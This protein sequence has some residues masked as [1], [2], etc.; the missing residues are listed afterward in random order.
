MTGGRFDLGPIANP[1]YQQVA[2]RP[3]FDHQAC[4]AIVALAERGPWHPA[5]LATAGTGTASGTST[6]G[7]DARIRSAELFHLPDDDSW[8]LHRLVEA[9]AEINAE[10][11]RFELTGLFASDAPSVARYRAAGADHF[12]PHQDAGPPNSR[13]KLTFVV[14]LSPADSYAGGDLVIA[15]GAKVA[16]RERGTLVVFPSTLQHVVSPVTAGVRHVI[17]GWVLGPTVA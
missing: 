16:P 17:V 9:V 13:R 6:V 1:H 15:D 5:G 7:Y 8:G 14:Q 10:V 11:H 3:L 12:R 4:D 2:A